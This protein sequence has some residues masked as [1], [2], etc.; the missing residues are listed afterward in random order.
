MTIRGTWNGEVLAESDQTVVVGGITTS[1][2]PTFALSTSSAAREILDHV[3]FW[4]G[5]EV[6]EV[7]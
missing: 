7:T 4:K 5:V 6:A 2:K 3:A 1:P